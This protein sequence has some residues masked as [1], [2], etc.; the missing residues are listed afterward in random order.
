MIPFGVAGLGL[1]LQAEPPA[2]EADIEAGKAAVGQTVGAEVGGQASACTARP[3]ERRCDQAVTG[4]GTGVE[5]AQGGRRDGAVRS[6]ESV[7]AV[8]GLQLR[9]QPDHEE[10][11]VVV[12]AGH[13]GVAMDEGVVA[14]QEQIGREEVSQV[15]IRR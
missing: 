14:A 2:A 1:Q 5:T 15:P 6:L 7:P 9:A 4:L 3:F 13:V 10:V 8:A 12:L 11:L